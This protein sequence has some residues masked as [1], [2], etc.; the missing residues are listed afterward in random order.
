MRKGKHNSIPPSPDL[1]RWN[2]YGDF[3]LTADR[4]LFVDGTADVWRDL[5]Y[6]SNL[7]P[8]RQWSDLHPEHLINGAG[9]VW[10]LRTQDDLSAE[11][12]FIREANYLEIR[13]VE[14]WLKEYKSWKPGMS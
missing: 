4:L 9:H 5:C 14:R 2:V 11:P 6:H 10:D 12:D 13:T 1:D 8:Q 7:A 3:N